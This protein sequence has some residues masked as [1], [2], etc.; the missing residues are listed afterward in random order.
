MLIEF[1]VQNYRSISEKQTF[2]MVKGKG[3]ELDSNWFEPDAPASPALLKSTAIYG[4][5]GSGKSN[6]MRAF[7]IMNSIVSNS[8]TENKRGDELPIEPFLFDASSNKE[9]T[10]FEVTFIQNSVK[11]QYGFSINKNR[12][13][14]EWLFAFPKG[15]PQ[16]WFIRAFDEENKKYHWAFSDL[17][18][19]QKNIWKESTKK[20]SL[21]LSTAVML[22]SEQLRDVYDW[23]DLK[24][25]FGQP[26]GWESSYSTTQCLQ[27]NRKKAILSL[28]NGADLGIDDIEVERKEFD[29]SLLSEEIPEGFKNE[30]IKELSG[31]VSAN[32]KTIHTLSNGQKF[33]LDLDEESDG[34]IKFFGLAAPLIDTLLNGRIWFIDELQNSLHPALVEYIISLFNSPK[35]NTTNAQLVFTTHET[36]LLNQNIFRRDQIWFCEKQDNRKS[37]IYPLTKF[38][39][40]KGVENLENA[41]H[42]GRYGAYPFVGQTPDFREWMDG[43]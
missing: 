33:S 5:N 3:N 34:T 4:S 12:I 7:M 24:L 25:K 13:L 27:E 36:S 18:K 37:T 14:E 21:F 30:L 39:P 6:L 10:E 15:S 38:K 35:S 22:N 16:R 17:L 11:Y 43:K 32:T 8:A 23:F 20:N 42:N 1:T 19:G 28:L 40:R 41:Y 26:S 2:S 29:P 31:K 9:P